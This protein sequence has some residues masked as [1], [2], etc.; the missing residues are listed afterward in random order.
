MNKF[1]ELKKENGV[2]ISAKLRVQIW[3]LYIGIGIKQITC[4]LCGLHEI[5]GPT[6]N[7]GFQACHIVASKFSPSSTGGVMDVFYLFPGC[8]TCNNECSD[9][10]LLDFLYT[11]MRYKQLQTMIWNIFKAFTVVHEKELAHH[12]GLCWRIL[13]HLY[14]AKKF[15]AGGGI[16]NKWAIYQMANVE[17]MKHVNGRVKELT[18]QLSQN[19]MLLNKLTCTEI[20]PLLLL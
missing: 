17:Q 18:E 11:R 20:K 2:K 10:C 14:G 3:E 7:S 16:E 19:V 13:D 5:M 12:E 9:Q 4:P 6:Q 15:P 1:L 8:Q